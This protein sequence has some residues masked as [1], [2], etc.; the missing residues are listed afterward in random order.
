MV[1]RLALPEKEWNDERARTVFAMPDTHLVLKM[2]NPEYAAFIEAHGEGYAPGRLVSV[3]E[4]Y[5]HQVDF[6]MNLNRHRE[7]SIFK[8]ITVV[9]VV[10]DQKGTFRQRVMDH[11]SPGLQ[12]GSAYQGA[13][14]T[15]DHLLAFLQH[16]NH[17]IG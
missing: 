5:W 17:Q 7:Y 12:W 4:M 14:E 6:L 1:Y 3:N 16:V 15:D 2:H 11:D 8:S 10:N 9:E 13:V